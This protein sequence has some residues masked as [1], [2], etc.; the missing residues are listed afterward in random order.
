MSII[1]TVVDLIRTRGGRGSVDDLF[2]VLSPKGITKQQIAKALERGRVTKRLVSEG[3]R[4]QYGEG[5][6][7]SLPSIH[8]LG[9]RELSRAN[10]FIRPTA[11]PPSSIFELGQP[12]ELLECW[13]MQ[14][15]ELRAV[16]PLGSWHSVEEAA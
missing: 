14:I 2:P 3:P 6:K 8:R 16:R 13:P 11:K 15:G 12:R 5:Q 4:R 7:S 1:D 9:P 10:V